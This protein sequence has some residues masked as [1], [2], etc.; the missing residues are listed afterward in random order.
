MHRPSAPLGQAHPTAGLLPF[1]NPVETPGMH[2]PSAPL[3][4]AQPTAGN[5]AA[6]LVKGKPSTSKGL[7]PTPLFP[8]QSRVIRPDGEVRAAKIRTA[9]GKT[10]RPISNLHPWKFT[11]TIEV[12]SS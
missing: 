1:P 12:S 4:Q 3:G 7:L 8:I 5:G 9:G 2:R 6:C 11:E 10:N